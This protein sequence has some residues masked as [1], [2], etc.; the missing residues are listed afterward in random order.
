[1]S[2]AKHPIWG[3]V[4]ILKDNKDGTSQCEVPEIGEM[5]LTNVYLKTDA[6]PVR[7]DTGSKGGS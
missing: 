1:M 3:E 2:K 4:E 5:T 6:K 7:A